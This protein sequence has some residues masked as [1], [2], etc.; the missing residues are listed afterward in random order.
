MAILC[1]IVSPCYNV[2]CYNYDSIQPYYIVIH[3]AKKGKVENNRLS[4]NVYHPI[5]DKIE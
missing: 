3:Y 5:R 1:F 4:L 2:S